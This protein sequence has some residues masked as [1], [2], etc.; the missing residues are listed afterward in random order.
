MTLDTF[1]G[2]FQSARDVASRRDHGM[3]S[4]CAPPDCHFSVFL[5]KKRQ[6]E[7]C[8]PAGLVKG[9]FMSMQDFSAED[10]TKGLRV[11]VD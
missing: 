1:R 4:M 6:W 8:L 7:S 3:E 5:Y 2:A 10:V 9:G 11:F